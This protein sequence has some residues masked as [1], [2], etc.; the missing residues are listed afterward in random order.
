MKIE[1]K[2]IKVKDLFSKYSDNGEDGV[3][4]YNGCLE[5]RPIYQREFI[6]KEDWRYEE[7][8]QDK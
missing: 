6:Y 1:L 4:G 8:G 2:N 3:I 5:I 7:V